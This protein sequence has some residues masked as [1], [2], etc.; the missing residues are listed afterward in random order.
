M[1]LI[2]AA[3]CNRGHYIVVLWFLPSIFLL[4][5][6]RLISAAADWMSIILPHMV[7]P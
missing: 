7:W 2:M 3:L 5:I 4:F 1:L 6:P